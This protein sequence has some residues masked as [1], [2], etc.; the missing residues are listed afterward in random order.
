MVPN[1]K[2][3]CHAEGG[4]HEDIVVP[5]EDVTIFADP[6]IFMRDPIETWLLEDRL[7]LLARCTR[8]GKLTVSSHFG[9]TA[10][11]L[12]QMLTI[13]KSSLGVDSEFND[14]VWNS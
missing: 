2:M 9:R 14:I 1:I 11:S 3:T 8:C 13:D 4:C 5:I 12:E 7:D 10:V 6:G